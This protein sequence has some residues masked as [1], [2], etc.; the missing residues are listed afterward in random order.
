MAFG[1]GSHRLDEWSET[2]LLQLYLA[3]N[4]DAIT[5]TFWTTPVAECGLLLL[6]GTTKVNA[7]VGGVAH[8]LSTSVR[9]RIE[10]TAAG[11]QVV[12][13]CVG[14]DSTDTGGT[15]GTMQPGELLSYVPS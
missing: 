13:L 8:G 11:V 15:V 7:W 10:V 1:G 3:A 9:A 5:R 12:D 6:Y 4:E 14:N 2:R